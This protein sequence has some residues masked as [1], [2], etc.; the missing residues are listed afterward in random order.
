MCLFQKGYIDVMVTLTF[1]GGARSVTGANYLVE[2]ANS[3]ILVDCGLA[4][5][6]RYAEVQNYKNFS[7]DPKTIDAVVITHAHIDHTGRLPKLV[8]DGFRGKIFMTRPT[9]DLASIMLEDAQ[10]LIG[11]EA[12][13]DRHEPLYLKEDK[14][15][16]IKLMEGVDYGDEIEVNKD[17]KFRLRDAGHILGSAIVEMWVEGKKIV[18]SGDLGNPPVPLLKP[19]EYIDDAEYV[20]VESTYGD[21]LHEAV[22]ERRNML[23]DAIEDTV[24][25][26]GVLMIPA[27]ALERTQELLYELNSLVENHRIPEVPIFIDS[28]LAIDATEIYKKYPEYYNKN[29][30]Y[31]IE[32]GDQLFKFPRLKLCYTTEE[33]KAINDVPAPKIIIAGSGMSSGGRIL[34]HERRYLS[35]PN[36]LFLIIG[37]QS[38]GSLGRAV[39]DKAR[40]VKIMGESV[41]VNCEIRAIGGYSAHADQAKLYHWV[42]HIKDGGKLKKVF[43]VQGEDAASLAFVRLLRDNLGVDADAPLLGDK[44][45]L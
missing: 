24:A 38:A 16:T 20:V 17:I 18:F 26:G 29:A 4:Q 5:G 36:S 13:R 1:C 30:V 27:F 35:D 8:R 6:S 15:N 19:T 40:E 43:A 11:E 9:Q 12:R 45:E 2:T 31:L 42:S 7:Y 44:V 22:D 3:K 33:S 10:G 25:R 28:P 39:F 37:Y 23:E 21:R 34:H 41:R 14:E 32:S